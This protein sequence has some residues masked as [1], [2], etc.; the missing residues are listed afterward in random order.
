MDIPLSVCEARDPKGLYK[1]ARA[2]KIKGKF[3]IL[4]LL[5]PWLKLYSVTSTGFTGI[6]DPYEAPLNSEVQIYPLYDKL[7][8]SHKL[9]SQNTNIIV[10]V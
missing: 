10:I 9:I 8:Q 1:L 4:Q 5:N 3:I 6:D 2:G 7:L